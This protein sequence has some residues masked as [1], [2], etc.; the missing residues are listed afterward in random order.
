[1]KAGIKISEIILNWNEHNFNAPFKMIPMRLHEFDLKLGYYV[2]F[3]NKHYNF[4]GITTMIGVLEGSGEP[5]HY[6]LF[7]FIFYVQESILSRNEFDCTLV[8]SSIIKIH[9]LAE[10]ISPPESFEILRTWSQNQTKNVWITVQ[11]FLYHN[12]TIRYNF[13]S[14]LSDIIPNY[15]KWSRTR[16][17]DYFYHKW[18]L[19]E[20]NI[21]KTLYMFLLL[22]LVS[23]F[24]S[25]AAGMHHLEAE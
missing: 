2:I 22:K 8:T 11:K 7:D 9:L 17:V 15:V 13:D 14:I 16:I 19:F 25:N 20:F 4:S 6:C 1:M 3:E 18:Y 5:C 23:S 12:I 10:R 24:I 21:I